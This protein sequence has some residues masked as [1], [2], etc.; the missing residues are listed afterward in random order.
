MKRV[1]LEEPRK[2]LRPT[3]ISR[4]SATGTDALSAVGVVQGNPT[5]LSRC[6]HRT[7]EAPPTARGYRAI[8]RKCRSLS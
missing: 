1:H 8:G 5:V 6:S 2:P 4:L 7:Y 3:V